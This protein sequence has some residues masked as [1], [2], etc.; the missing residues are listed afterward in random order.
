[1]SELRCLKSQGDIWYTVYRL[2][3]GQ[4]GRYSGTFNELLRSL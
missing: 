3:C 4:K 1:M 2:W